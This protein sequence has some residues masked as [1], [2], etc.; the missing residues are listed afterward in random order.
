MKG[1]KIAYYIVFLLILSVLTIESRSQHI[2]PFVENYSKL[3]YRGDN[4][5]WGLAQGDDN[6]MYFANNHY[7][8]RFNGVRWEKFSLPNKTIIRSVFSKNNRIYTGSFNEFGFWTRK[9][10]VLTYTSMVPSKDF[11]SGDSRNEEIW[12]IFEKD[13]DIY[14]QT[15][16]ELYVQIGS[17]IKKYRFPDIISYTFVANHKIFVATINKGI[18]TFEKG[19]FVEEKYLETLKGKIIH[20]IEDFAGKEYYFTRNDGVYI[21]VANQLTAWK[22][23]LN[24]K[25]K[26]EIIITAKIIGQK[27][28]L[29]IG[30]SSNG[31]YIIDLLTGNYSN[32]NRKNSLQ[33]NS[34]LSISID[35]ENDVWLGLDNGISHVELNSP[36]QFFTDKEGTLGSVYAIEKYGN[37]LLV[38]SNH[39]LFVYDNNKLEQVKN[40]QGQVWSIFN[41]GNEY[42]IGHNDGTFLLKNQEFTRINDNTGGWK[43]QKDEY[44]SRLIQASYTGVIFY[45]ESDFFSYGK[46]LPISPMPIKDIAQISDYQLVLAHNLQGLFMVTYDKV[47]SKAELKNLSSELGNDFGVKIFNYRGEKLFLINNGWYYYDKLSGKLKPNELFNLNFPNTSEIIPVN[48]SLFIA[49]QE[50]IMFIIK[51]VKEKFLKTAIPSKYYLGKLINN[52]T[53]AFS[54]DGQYYLNLDDGFMLI[55][56]F[57]EEFTPQKI[58]I[59]AYLSDYQFF[60]GNKIANNSSITLDFV[61]EYFGSKKP[62]INYS[63]N[64]GEIMSLTNYQLVMNNLGSGTYKIRAFSYNGKE[65][66][67]VNEFLFTVRNP[68]FLAWWMFLVYSSVLIVISFL[69]YRWN[70]LRFNQKLKL[71]EEELKHHNE[72]MQLEMQAEN[73]LKMQ[74]F[75]KQTLRN[76]V[77]VKSNEVAG[78]SLYLAKQTELIERIQNILDSENSVTTL[79]SKISSAIKAVKINKN[80]WKS[81]EDNLLK[82]NEDFVKILT[83]KYSSL[84][85]KDIKLCIYLKMNLSSKEIAPMMNI[86]FRGVELHRYRLRKKLKVNTEENLVLFMNNLK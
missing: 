65:N 74:E 4:Q 20:H 80:E 31:V 21:S 51:Q 10:G 77:K 7:L 25:L 54:C 1:L 49:I 47:L 15:F 55:K 29:V 24:E 13:G 34:V 81:F 35:K 38:G 86:S 3:D 22:H 83:S 85:P 5:I 23:D 42:I 58:T 69:Y 14:F 8:L 48:D 53:K 60:S 19:I 43:I 84:T 82:S 50:N 52:E 17:E 40:S 59:E 66:L 64:D 46:R 11:F 6:A 73:Q 2:L 78:K 63:I 61:P 62:I 45:P 75:E 41:S 70:K 76:E 26:E 44:A 37:G 57:D 9:N 67:F 39:G 28:T 36:F 68:W 32:I 71:K 30:T 16:N 56:S 72:I 79:K 27:N 33:N 18:F 12:K